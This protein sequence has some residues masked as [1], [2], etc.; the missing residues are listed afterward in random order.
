M[1]EPT[2]NY[3]AMKGKSSTK[4]YAEQSIQLPQSNNEKLILIALPALMKRG[5][6]MGTTQKGGV[7][8]PNF[9]QG[10]KQI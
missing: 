6:S 5:V 2:K 8:G 3:L 10:S 4:E 1:S 9:G 7:I